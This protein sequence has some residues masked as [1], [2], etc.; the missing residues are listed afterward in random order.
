[1]FG[2]PVSQDIVIYHSSTSPSR[3]VDVSVTRC[4]IC[5]RGGSLIS[6]PVPAGHSCFAMRL[7]RWTWHDPCQLTGNKFG[8]PVRARMSTYPKINHDRNDDVSKCMYVNDVHNRLSL[9]PIVLSL[10]RHRE[11]GCASRNAEKRTR[12]AGGRKTLL[13]KPSLPYG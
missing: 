9:F 10:Y 8:R 11:R 4:R 7:P 6:R 2:V 13:S 1:M 5:K 12:T 3:R